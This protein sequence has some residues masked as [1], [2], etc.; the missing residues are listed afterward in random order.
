MNKRRVCWAGAAILE[1]A[2][3]LALCG[4]S[5]DPE[6]GFAHVEVGM[7]ESEVV[8]R[9]GRPDALLDYTRWQAVKYP[10]GWHGT[11]W[12]APE[13]VLTV[14]FDADGQVAGKTRITRPRE[15]WLQRVRRRIRL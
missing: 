6:A 3:G 1:V 11:V 8:A 10:A 14:D 12:Y 15:P 9:F 13:A 4:L 7:S 2:A 5:A